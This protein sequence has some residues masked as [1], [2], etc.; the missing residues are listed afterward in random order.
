MG[1]I[2]VAMY[3]SLDGV[4]ETPSWTAPYCEETLSDYQDAAQREC[5]ALLLGRITYEQFAAAWPH[6]PDEGALH[7]RH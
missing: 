4:M 7:E 5:T 3:V 6:S 2:V 1:R